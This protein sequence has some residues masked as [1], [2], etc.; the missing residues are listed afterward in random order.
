MFLMVLYKIEYD[1]KR[2]FIDLF[3]EMFIVEGVYVEGKIWF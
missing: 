1:F 2:F 3:V